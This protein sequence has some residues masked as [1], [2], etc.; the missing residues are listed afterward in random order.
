MK[1]LNSSLLP[2]NTL[3]NVSL[4]L[5][6][7][8]IIV[9]GGCMKQPEKI[10]DIT[11]TTQSNEAKGFFQQGLALVDQGDF[12]KSRAMFAKAIESDPKLAIAYI[13]KAQTGNSPKE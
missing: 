2:M 11:V 10:T 7:A 8:F 4:P 3:R 1:K 12:Q 13:F 6:L 9:L 5:T